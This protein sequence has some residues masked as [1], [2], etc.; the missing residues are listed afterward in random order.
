MLARDRAGMTAGA[1]ATATLMPPNVQRA[2]AQGAPRHGSLKD[3]EHV[4][5]H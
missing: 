2:L 4:P 3:I 1:A 5:R